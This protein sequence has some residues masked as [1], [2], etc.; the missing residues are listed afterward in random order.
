MG[1]MGRPKTGKL[2]LEPLALGHWQQP[3]HV[4]VLDELQKHR[5][6][7]MLMKLYH[8]LLAAMA[9]TENNLNSKGA[10]LVPG[11]GKHGIRLKPC[12]LPHAKLLLLKIS[13]AHETVIVHTLARNGLNFSPK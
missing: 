7:K 9:R 13:K 12:N 1:G 10:E 2:L 3:T 6:S 8:S 4:T 11:G 5:N